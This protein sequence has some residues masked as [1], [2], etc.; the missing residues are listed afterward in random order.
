MIR[1]T[2]VLMI[3][4]KIET[5]NGSPRKTPA[6]IGVRSVCQHLVENAA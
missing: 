6:W 1:S 2:E 3:V 4:L 5:D